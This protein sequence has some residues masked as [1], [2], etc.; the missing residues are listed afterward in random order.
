VVGEAV[1]EAVVVEVA[2]V[3]DE[4]EEEN[5]QKEE[6]KR[7]LKELEEEVRDPLEDDGMH[8]L[9]NIDTWDQH[10]RLWMSLV[11]MWPVVR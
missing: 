6:E 9:A 10:D 5:G 8:M 3:E 11:T 2:L 1:V 4:Q 7:G